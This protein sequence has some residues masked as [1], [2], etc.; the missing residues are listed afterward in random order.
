MK[1]YN[2]K[3]MKYLVNLLSEFIL[4]KLPKSEDS[5]I[6]V[7]YISNFFVV[8][9]STTSKTFLDF[10]VIKDEFVKEYGELIKSWNNISLNFLDV[11]K[12]EKSKFN[13]EIIFEFTKDGFPYLNDNSVVS[14]FPV[15]SIK[16][17]FPY[18]FS[19]N[20]DRLLMYYLQY[21]SSHLF[22]ITDSSKI[23]YTCTRELDKNE[24]SLINLE[25]DSIYPNNSILSMVLDVFDFNLNNFY[26]NKMGEYPLL[27]DITHHSEEKPWL[28]RDK[29]NEL[30]LF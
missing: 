15:L 16:S 30:I 7:I 1:V 2:D 17:E 18:G 8:N 22:K 10:S 6:E 9:G 19:L 28:V 29:T 5:I 25:S 26:K 3:S 13:E 14:P 21:V 23:K 20:Y 12:Y 27:R 11:I 4:Y 24:V